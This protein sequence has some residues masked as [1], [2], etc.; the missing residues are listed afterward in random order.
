MELLIEE[1]Q[2]EFQEQQKQM[3]VDIL[4]IGAQLYLVIYILLQAK[5]LKH[6]CNNNLII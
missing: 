6:V 2:S 5:L 4:K 1:R 3:D